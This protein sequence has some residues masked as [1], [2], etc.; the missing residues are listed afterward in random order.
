MGA[1]SGNVGQPGTDF[2]KFEHFQRGYF[3]I[4]TGK[5]GCVAVVPV[6]LNTVSS[7]IFDKK[8]QNIKKPV[9]VQR[10]QRLGHFLYGG[11][12]CI[13]IF[14]PKQYASDSIR[15]RL[16]NQIGIFDTPPQ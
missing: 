6:G 9:P 8:F 15:V 2:S 7:I 3:I 16:G 1:S 12:L 4:D 13:L 14:E 10:G 5:Y 11:S